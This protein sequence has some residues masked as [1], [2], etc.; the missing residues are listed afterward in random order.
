LLSD[1]SNRAYFTDTETL[2]FIERHHNGSQ[3]FTKLDQKV[4]TNHWGFVFTSN[5]FIFK[6]F[7]RRISQLVESGLVQKTI[8]DEAEFVKHVKEEE[9]TS[10]SLEHFEYWMK[11]CAILL[12]VS[13]IAFVG[14]V[15]GRRLEKAIQRKFRARLW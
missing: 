1:G 10:L 3:N 15:L 7:N 6:A 8:R 5:D 12:G 4:L 14:E 11:L 13:V 9:P 2:S